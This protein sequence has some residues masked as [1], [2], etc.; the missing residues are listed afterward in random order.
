MPEPLDAEDS[1][2]VTLARSAFVRTGS[3]EAAAV[4]DGTGRTYVAGPVRL[5]S[6]QLSALQAVV[7]AAVSSGAHDL[8]AAVVVRD[9]GPPPE[10]DLAVVGELSRGTCPVYLVGSDGALRVRLSPS[11]P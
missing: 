11:M 10:A 9:G 8:E 4:R 7:A 5:A 1:K 3:G 6:L 2:L